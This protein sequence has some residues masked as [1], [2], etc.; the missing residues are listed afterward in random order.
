MAIINTNLER[1]RQGTEITIISGG[2]SSEPSPV[3]PL[4]ILEER[5]QALQAENS[6]LTARNQLLKGENTDLRQELAALGAENQGLRDK[7]R[8]WEDYILRFCHDAKNALTAPAVHLQ[9][10]TR[11]G[12]PTERISASLPGIYKGV[13]DVR[14]RLFAFPDQLAMAG[15]LRKEPMDIVTALGSVSF[16]VVNTARKVD[17]ETMGGLELQFNSPA[18]SQIIRGDSENLNAAFTDLIINAIQAMSGC[19]VKQLTISIQP[20]AK[21]VSIFIKDTGTGIPVNI[22]DRIFDKGFT[23]KADG[24]GNGLYNV[25]N[26]IAA[27]GGKIKIKETGPCGTTFEV[28]LPY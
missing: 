13:I 11:P 10:I 22:K 4:T 15:G 24:N 19:P 21:E 23:T 27:H 9:R 2:V 5:N 26:R 8:T 12:T 17:E 7:I 1:E 6:T 18:E 20:G 3:N 16:D 28:C 14:N 25:Q